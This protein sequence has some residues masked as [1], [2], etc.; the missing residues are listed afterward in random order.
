MAPTLGYWEIR[1]LAAP[2]RYLLEYAGQSYEEKLY[3]G[4]P[5]PK[6]DRSHWLE[7][8]FT[9]GLDFPNLPYY[10]DGDVKVSQSQVILRHLARKHG[11]D[12]KT[13]ADKLRVEL[14][15]AQVG[16]YQ[17]DFARIVYNPQFNELKGDY[18]AGLPD[19]L[20][21]LS[22]FL[23]DRKFVAGDYVTY[24]DFILFEYLEGQAYFVEGLLK[25]Y[26]VLDAFHKRV[27][28][29][30]AIDKYVKSDKFIKFPF[31]G[32]PAMFGGPFS[33]QLSKS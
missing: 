24:V 18:K 19:K 10:I 13:E 25:D 3:K 28:A 14:A 2:I 6:F 29:L 21:A 5:P 12:G 31:N 8:K 11:L 9:L 32:S 23:G 4:G 27:L 33:E 16:D 30:P 15:L 17:T 22:N 7:D 1:G 26:P 20:K